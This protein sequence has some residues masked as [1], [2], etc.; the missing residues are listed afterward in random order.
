MLQ[1]IQHAEEIA[2]TQTFEE[3][4]ANRTTKR[5]IERLVQIITE[6]SI[7]LTDEDRSLCK[8][9]QWQAMRGLG[10]RI[11]HTYFSLDDRQIWL[12][13]KDDLPSLKAAVEQTLREHFS[14]ALDR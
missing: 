5:A 11:R 12:I 9:T 4:L 7:Q 8:Y 6:A 14:E 1:A 10:N 3:Y 13:V 2:G